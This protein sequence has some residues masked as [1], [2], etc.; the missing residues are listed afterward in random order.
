VPL[1][2]LAGA[3]GSVGRQAASVIA[4]DPGV[5]RA[6]VLVAKRDVAGLVELARDLHPRVV[7][8]SDERAGPAL[9][10]A[11]G[12]DAEVVAGKEAIAVLAEADI[13][14]NAVSGF[15][16]LE[17]TEVALRAGRRLALANKESLVAAGSLVARWLSEG[18]GELV[19]VDSEH[20]AIFQCLG[21]RTE[22]GAEVAALVLTSSGGPF[23]TTP[24]HQLLG[25]RA[26]D[27]LAHPTW[28]MGPKIT[29]DSST[30]FNKG[31]E[32]IE[33]HYLFGV[34]YDA[35]EVVVHPESVVHSM[36][37]F[38]DGSVLAQL[39]EPTMELPIAVALYHPRRAPQPAARL[40]LAS[41]RSLTFEPVD[42]ERFPA[43][44]I[45]FDVGRLAGGAPCW[46]NAANEVAVA[47]FLV[48]R[49]RWVDI[50]TVVRGALD[51]YE[52]SEP[53]SVDEVV[54]LDAAARRAAH[55][56][57]EALHGRR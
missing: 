32:V 31:L 15:A 33:A 28:T 43:L 39:C 2:A 41:P 52:P 20:S 37:R 46:M 44:Q 55:E 12:A 48:G 42:H 54:A 10:E 3:T 38:R 5:L 18:A 23:R 34:D 9:L 6:D 40:D 21:G 57:V 25:V 11:I 47:A 16:G 53:R 13:V 24:A 29:V 22:P 35:I 4:R 30:L 56:V 14:L 26:E 27:A 49:I 45:A 36:V 50:V 8:V 19:P 1:V 17:V 7:G 51:R